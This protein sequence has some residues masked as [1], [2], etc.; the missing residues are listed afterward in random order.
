MLSCSM[1]VIQ[2]YMLNLLDFAHEVMHCWGLFRL[3]TVT[4]RY[5]WNAIRC[6]IDLERSDMRYRFFLRYLS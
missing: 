1:S 4:Q 3:R 6:V 5:D 2:I